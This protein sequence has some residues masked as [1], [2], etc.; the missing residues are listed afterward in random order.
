MDIIKH[1]QDEGVII[2]VNETRIPSPDEVVV[3]ADETCEMTP[4]MWDKL[5]ERVKNK[6][7]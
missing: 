5:A 3:I 2:A 6:A 7:Q 4:E 1:K